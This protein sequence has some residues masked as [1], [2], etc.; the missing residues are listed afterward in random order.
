MLS[1]TLH[2]VRTGLVIALLVMSV[3]SVCAVQG[4]SASGGGNAVNAKLCQKGGWSKVMDS[5]AHKFADEDACVSYAAHNGA[6][7][8]LATLHIDACKDQPY[9]GLCIDLTG[10]G[11]APGSVADTTI[12]KNGLVIREDWPIVQGDG[13]VNPSPIAHF[14]VQCV[15]GDEYSASAVGTSA[16]SLTSPAQ[17]GIPITSNTVERTAACP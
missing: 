3:G 13:T 1:H 15:A 4:A 6:I 5:S 10:S 11:L 7:Y 14:E 17:A 2:N 8:S 9:D 16:D 12:S